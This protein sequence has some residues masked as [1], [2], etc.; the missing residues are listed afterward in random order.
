MAVLLLREKPLFP[1]PFTVEHSTPAK[2]G[3]NALGQ[4]TVEWQ[5]V[6]R[7]VYGWH[8][9]SGSPQMT[10]AMADRVVTELSLLTPEP[11]WSHGDVVTI[12][13]RGDFKVHGDVHD[14]NTGPFG[15]TPGYKVTLRKVHVDG[16]A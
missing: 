12:P 15:F 2:T 5:T 7:S 10:P 16:P 6:T 8:A 9:P 3:E 4:A 13:G 1:T 14:C 11:G